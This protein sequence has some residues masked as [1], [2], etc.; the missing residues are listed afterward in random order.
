MHEHANG[1]IRLREEF[2]LAQDVAH[3]LVLGRRAVHEL[4]GLAIAGKD[5]PV[6]V[7]VAALEHGAGKRLANL[8]IVVADGEAAA[9][10]ARNLDLVPNGRFEF[11]LGLVE[12]TREVI[13]DAALVVAVRVILI[14]VV[15]ADDRPLCFDILAQVKV[16]IGVQLVVCQAKPRG[17][18]AFLLE[19]LEV[20]GRESITRTIIEGE[21]R[22]LSGFIAKEREP[23][24]GIAPGD[25]RVLHLL[26]QRV[27]L[28]GSDSD[29]GLGLLELVS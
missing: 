25:I 6:E 13:V 16:E 11:G 26:L 24:L 3:D 10:K 4:R 29:I 23:A 15:Y 17:D 14:P 2:R 12:V 20:L 1:R 9:R 8:G 21:V 19:N 5:V 18:G 27:V 28:L 22:H 7:L